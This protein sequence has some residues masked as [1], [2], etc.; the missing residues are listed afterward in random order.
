MLGGLFK[1]SLALKWNLATLA[2][3]INNG[4]AIVTGRSQEVFAREVLVLDAAVVLT[5]GMGRV[6]GLSLSV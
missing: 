3:R 2:G 5:L 1:T 6:I 4:F